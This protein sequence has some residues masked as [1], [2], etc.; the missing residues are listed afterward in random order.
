MSL[1]A[2]HECPTCFGYTGW[3]GERARRNP[4]RK[5]LACVCEEA[6]EQAGKYA[7]A[8]TELGIAPDNGN[9]R[10]AA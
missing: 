6:A 5:H 9:A 10:V 7:L 8:E 3:A 4:L 2:R 1:L